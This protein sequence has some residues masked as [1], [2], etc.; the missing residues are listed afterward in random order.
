MDPLVRLLS[1]EVC[2]KQQKPLTR[3]DLMVGWLLCLRP[4]EDPPPS[5]TTLTRADKPLRWWQCCELPGG[6]LAHACL[7][8]APEAA[9]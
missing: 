1:Q 3:D 9:T 8:I 7:S 5:P 6:D 2:K 4:T